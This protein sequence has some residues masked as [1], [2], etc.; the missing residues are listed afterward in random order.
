VETAVWA[1]AGEAGL[2][3]LATLCYGVARLGRDWSGVFQ[4]QE[5]YK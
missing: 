1:R 5:V 4:R 3:G 2:V